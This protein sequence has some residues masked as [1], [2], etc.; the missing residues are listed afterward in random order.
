MKLKF[1]SLLLAACAVGSAAHAEESRSVHYRI[2]DGC[3]WFGSSDYRQYVCG[4][5]IAPPFSTITWVNDS[6]SSP[7]RFRW[8][9]NDPTEYNMVETWYNRTNDH[10]L[11]QQTGSIYMRYVPTLE[12]MFANGEATDTVS[13]SLLNSRNEASYF[14]AGGHPGGMFFG[15]YPGIADMECQSWG[16]GTYN[17][18]LGEVVANVGSPDNYAFGTGSSISQAGATGL[19][20]IYHQ[21]GASYVIDGGVGAKLYFAMDDEAEIVIT[22]RKATKVSDSEY[23]LGEEIGHII[24]TGAYM[25]SQENLLPIG[26]GYYGFVKWPKFYRTDADGNEEEMQ[27][28]VDTALAVVFS[29]WDSDLVDFFAFST[30]ETRSSD[31][32]TAAFWTGG[33]LGNS[34][35]AK[36]AYLA[37]NMA[38]Y[39]C[40]S[41]LYTPQTEFTASSIGEEIEFNI[42][43]YWCYAD[44]RIF[45]DGEEKEVQQV[46]DAQLTDWLSLYYRKD[47]SSTQEVNK[48]TLTV[49]PNSGAA[50]QAVITFMDM[51]GRTLDVTVT[52][53]AS[54]SISEITAAPKDAEVY[55]LLGRRILSK[56]PQSGLYI[57][58]GHLV[59]K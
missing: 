14:Q 5:V 52:Q 26:N 3:F 16:F 31:V 20:C 56:A 27:P 36:Y 24:T 48:M 2:P 39:G 38:L 42:D 15:N 19:A 40:F 17:L 59:R 28:M 7:E 33:Q 49:A 10:D 22:L 32:E 9:Y 46:R 21:P 12:G 51:D 44:L 1:M 35:Q 43:Q 58:N 4:S 55:D 6:E 11:T 30:N 29:G 8:T 25:K 45:V 18:R 41:Y 37:P 34:A 23:T 57:S 54:A 13:Y 53:S 47:L 50:R